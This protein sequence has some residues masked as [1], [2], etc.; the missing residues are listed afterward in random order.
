MRAA[1]DV[2][3]LPCHDSVAAAVAHL[4]AGPPFTGTRPQDENQAYDGPVSAP[5]RDPAG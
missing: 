5:E 3:E 2:L 4:R 1:A